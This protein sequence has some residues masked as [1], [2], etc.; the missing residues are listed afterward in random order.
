LT[1]S[2]FFGSVYLKLLGLQVC[3]RHSTASLHE[4]QQNCLV[5]QR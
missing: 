4:Q 5:R 2:N 3:Y 1:I